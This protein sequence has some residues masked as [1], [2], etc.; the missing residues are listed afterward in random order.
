MFLASEGP[1]WL[2]FAPLMLVV[3]DEADGCCDILYN[4]RQIRLALLWAFADSIVR[5]PFCTA[6]RILGSWNRGT[7]YVSSPQAADQINNVDELVKTACPGCAWVMGVSWW[8]M[9]GRRRV[10]RAKACKSR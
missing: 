10:R 9:R 6:Y 4:G 3:E 1:A 5:N 2:A 8:R 7:L